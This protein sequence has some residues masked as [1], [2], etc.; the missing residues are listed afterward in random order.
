[1]RSVFVHLRAATEAEVI[2][3]LDASYPYQ[4]GPTWICAVD[5][6][7]CLYIDFY[8]DHAAESAPEDHAALLRAFGG[9]LPVSLVANVSGRWPGDEQA[10]DFVRLFL[11][12]FGGFAHDDYTEHLWTLEEVLSGAAIDGHPFF[13]HRSPRS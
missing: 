2:P 7:P 9:L 1:M 10:R 13:D 8:R 6:D 5:D 4:P 3:F 12:R 11:A